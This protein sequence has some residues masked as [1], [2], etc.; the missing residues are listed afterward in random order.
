MRFVKSY[1][2]ELNKSISPYEA[3]EVYFDQES[4]LY[5]KKLSFHCED[6]TRRVDLV[7]VNIYKTIRAKKASHYRTRPKVEHSLS[8]VFILM[9][10]RKYPVLP[11]RQQKMRV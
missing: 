6:E 2:T 4:H 1:C 3:R 8:V 11:V 5:Q 7:A 9:K 10:P